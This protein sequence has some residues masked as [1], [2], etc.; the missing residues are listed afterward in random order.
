MG[1]GGRLGARPGDGVGEVAHVGVRLRGVAGLPVG[2]DDGET[3]LSGAAH[4][5]MCVPRGL[6]E[7]WGL[8]SG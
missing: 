4:G 2:V 8:L 1:V 5:R 6:V 7:A 3:G